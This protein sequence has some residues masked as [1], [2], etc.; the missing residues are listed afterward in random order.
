MSGLSMADILR[1]GLDKPEPDTEASFERGMFEGY[2]IGK[3]EFEVL[4]TRSGCGKAHL[5]VVGEGTKAVA[6]GRLI[7]RSARSCR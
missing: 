1:A 2:R 7:D 3:E 5:P 6:A 4:A